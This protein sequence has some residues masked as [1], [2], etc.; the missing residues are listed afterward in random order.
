MRT[1]HIKNSTQQVEPSTELQ[2]LAEIY[3]EEHCRK[4]LPEDK[5]LPCWCEYLK[6]RAPGILDRPLIQLVKAVTRA[7]EKAE[8]Q[9]SSRFQDVSASH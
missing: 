8:C 3:L 7:L 9:T 5:V 6:T 1:Q 4:G 2:L